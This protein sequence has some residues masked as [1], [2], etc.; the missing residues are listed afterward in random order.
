M[1]KVLS[2]V[3]AIALLV[4]FSS[5]VLATTLDSNDPGSDLPEELRP[6]SNL[7]ISFTTQLE[8]EGI[9]VKT[10][11]EAFVDN[12]LLCGE[13]TLDEYVLYAISQEAIL[14]SEY[15]SSDNSIVSSPETDVEITSTGGE[16]YDYIGKN[17]LDLDIKQAPSYSKYNML[18]E[19]ASGDIIHET[20]GAIA[21]ITGHVAIVEGI[22]WSTQ[23]QAYYIRTI[24][25]AIKGVVYG[26]LD[27]ERYDERGVSVYYVVDATDDQIDNAVYFCEQQIGKPYN[28]D[29]IGPFGIGMSCNTSINSSKWYCSELLWAAYFDEGRGFNLNGNNIPTNI[30]SPYML[31]HCGELLII[32][33]TRRY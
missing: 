26:V 5:P 15:L 19:V 1:K 11:I 6:F 3:C 14:A 17:L 8:N 16:W 25:S 24:E 12:Y 27:D 13:M 2:I 7:Y 29:G 33:I 21:G 23:Y 4:C 20:V 9:P 30:Y 32:E 18:N 31:I 28:Y 22:Y 10:S